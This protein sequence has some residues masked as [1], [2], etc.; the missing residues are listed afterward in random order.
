MEA[1]GSSDGKIESEES[2]ASMLV[3]KPNN[4]CRRTLLYFVEGYD[5]IKLQV[6]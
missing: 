5:G 3:K 1:K 2:P 4:W 6:D